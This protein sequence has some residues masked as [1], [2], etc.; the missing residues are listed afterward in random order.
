MQAVVNIVM[1][2]DAMMIEETVVVGYGTQKK[3][4]LTGA[5]TAVDEKALE[6]RV[7]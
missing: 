3:V 5:I 4:N 2:E 6:D 7:A 1:K